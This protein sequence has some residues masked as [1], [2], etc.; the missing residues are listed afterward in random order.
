[1][2]KRVIDHDTVTQLAQTIITTRLLT[3]VT[4]IENISKVIVINYQHLNNYYL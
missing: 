2:Y 3:I 1:M 4:Q